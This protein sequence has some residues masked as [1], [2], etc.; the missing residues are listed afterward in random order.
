[1]IANTYLTRLWNLIDL[2]IERNFFS[3]NSIGKSIN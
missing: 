1:M 3:K 2:K